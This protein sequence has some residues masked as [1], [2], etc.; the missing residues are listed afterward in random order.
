MKLLSKKEYLWPSA[1]RL[2]LKSICL[3]ALL[4]ACSIVL[5][6]FLSFMPS[7]TIRF[8][9]GGIAISLASLLLGPL[10]GGLVGLLSDVIGILINPMGTPHLGITLNATLFGILPGL[11]VYLSGQLRLREVIFSSLL[12]TVLLSWLLKSVWIAQLT[13]LSYLSL[14]GSRL[15]AVLINA[16][17]SFLLLLFCLPLVQKMLKNYSQQA[18]LCPNPP[19]TV[20]SESASVDDEEA[21]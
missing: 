20:S 5:T 19:P 2:R 13:N 1:L 11:L 15:P 6:R 16:S 12:Q 4:L 7:S 3:A 8:S 17:V 10:F 21:K 9:L 18:S 14:L